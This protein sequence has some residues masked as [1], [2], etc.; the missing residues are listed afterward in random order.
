[1]KERTLVIVKPDAVERRI[2]GRIIQKIEDA[3]FTILALQMVRLTRKQAK[4]FYNVHRDKEFFPGLV[5]F[6]ISGPCIPL[7][8]ERENGVACMRKLAGKTDP[9]KAGPGTIRHEF[10]ES[11]RRNCVHASDGRD[12]ARAEVEFFFSSDCIL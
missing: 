9:A 5:D 6:M 8:A 3:G 11:L 10:G 4:S 2:I 1:M 12:T 7:L